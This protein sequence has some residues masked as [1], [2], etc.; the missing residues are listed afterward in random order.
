[1]QAQTYMQVA[2]GERIQSSMGIDAAQHC[3]TEHDL[4]GYAKHN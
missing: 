2:S 1:M 4:D 3:L